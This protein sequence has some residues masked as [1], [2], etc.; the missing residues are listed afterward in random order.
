[1]NRIAAVVAG[2][3]LAFVGTSASFAATIHVPGDHPTIAEAITASVDGDVINIAAGTY[4]EHSLNPVGKAIT[5]QGTLNGD[6]TNATTINAHQGGSVFKIFYGEDHTTVIKHLVITGGSGHYYGGGIMCNESSPTI[7]N[8]TFLNNTASTG[9]GGIYCTKSSPTI[10]DCLIDGNTSNDFGGGICCQT[11][12]NPTI[13]GCLI[14]SNT[15]STNSGGGGIYCT[16]SNPTITNCTIESNSAAS[17]GGID[18]YQSNPTITGGNI[19]GNTAHAGGGGIS[20]TESNP[21]ITGCTI[22]NNTAELGGGIYCKSNT[23]SGSGT[24]SN[25]TIKGNT[26]TDYDGGGIYCNNSNPTISGCTIKD[27]TSGGGSGGIDCY[28]SSPTITGCVIEGNSTSNGFAGGG[29]SCLDNSKPTITNCTISGN[30]TQSASDPNIVGAGG[31]IW[32]KNS[33]PTITGCTISGNTPDNVYGVPHGTPLRGDG[34][35]GIITLENCTICGTGEHVSGLIVHLGHN[36][37]SD[38][39]DDGDLDGDGDVDTEDLNALHDAL[40]IELTDVNNNGCVDIDDLLYVIEDWG[41][42]CTP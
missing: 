35:P 2:L 36:H 25:C 9:G 11:N 30:T 24:I 42:G 10:T 37:I 13:T 27:N 14:L 8:C 4:N 6:G 34:D 26:T 33:S 38:C 39:I 23:S 22:L 7:S 17:G 40:G 31:G 15:A 1:M 19:E 41:E 28:Q 21:N 29:I 20:W 5:I 3:L 12:S 32:C 18:C 16:N